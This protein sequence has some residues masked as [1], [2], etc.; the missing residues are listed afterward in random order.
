MTVD[1]FKQIRDLLNFESKDDFYYVEIMQ[2]RKDG[3]PTR[4]CNNVIIKNYFIKSLNYFDLVKDEMIGLARFFN[5]RIYIRL[6]K[7]SFKKCAMKMIMDVAVN[8]DTENWEGCKKSFVS[9]AGQYHND[10]NKT[11][12][13]DVDW[14]KNDEEES[15][16]A[17]K[18]MLRMADA[19]S[20]AR[21]NIEGVNKIVAKI[22]TVNGLHY[23]VKPFDLQTFRMNWSITYEEP[24][25]YD[26]HKDNPTLL[27]YSTEKIEDKIYKMLGMDEYL[28]DDNEFFEDEVKD[29]NKSN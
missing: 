4:D 14:N 1:N 2:R 6:N 8:I 16:K 3:N 26:I 9:V 22:P 28:S 7:R 27:F 29:E 13:I 25:P 10:K 20:D 12:I 17:F 21:P 23:L 11:W 24:F 15:K 19:I 5:A 18:N